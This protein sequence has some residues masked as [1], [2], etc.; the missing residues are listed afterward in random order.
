MAAMGARSPCADTGR[1]VLMTD[2]LH[3]RGGGRTKSSHIAPWWLTEEAAVFTI[4]LTHALISNFEG[5]RC[6]IDP[7]DQHA[8]P[9]CLQPQLFLILKRAHMR[10]H[11]EMM[12]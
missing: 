9:C 12:M 7:V 11:T 3:Q 4:E 6:R 10:Q 5:R 8:A 1:S 2:Q